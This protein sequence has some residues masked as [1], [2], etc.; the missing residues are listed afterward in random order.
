VD[1]AEMFPELNL[2]GNGLMTEAGVNR[3]RSR[4]VSGSYLDQVELL[5]I[6]PP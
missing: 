1:P 6:N 5:I 2:M 4:V 3:K